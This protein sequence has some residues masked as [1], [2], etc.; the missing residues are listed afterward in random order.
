MYK[1]HNNIYWLN[2]FSTIEQYNI[3]VIENEYL[4]VE[5]NFNE[6]HK[7]IEEKVFSWFINNSNNSYKNIGKVLLQ[8]KELLTFKNE[9]NKKHIK[10]EETGYKTIIFSEI[11]RLLFKNRIYNSE[12]INF[13][14]MEMIEDA[15]TFEE[16][17]LK[18][19]LKDIY[20]YNYV[21]VG[22]IFEEKLEKLQ[23]K[24]INEKVNKSWA[25]DNKNFCER[26][27]LLKI[28]VMN[29]I[30]KEV[31]KLC[32]MYDDI[33]KSIK[34]LKDFLEKKFKNIKMQ[35]RRL[36]ITEMRYFSTIGRFEAFKKL[37]IKKFYIAVD[38]DRDTSNI[39]Y[40]LIGKHFSLNDFCIGVTAPPFHVGCRSFIVPYVDI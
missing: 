7:S 40:K 1:K 10:I 21:E 9:L 4:K 22:K 17:V 16:M 35:C 33:E 5:K 25:S 18:N 26:I 15:F 19:T 29:D 6:I 12:F 34:N 38:R 24:D 13:Y 2:K 37:H 39:C 27:H 14:I 11:K 23:K 32:I 3:N 8:N 31:E 20:I 30:C 36:F 28:T